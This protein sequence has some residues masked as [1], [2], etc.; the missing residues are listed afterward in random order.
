[1]KKYIKNIVKEKNL[2]ND[3]KFIDH[4]MFNTKDIS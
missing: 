3:W 1:M 2:A 4:A